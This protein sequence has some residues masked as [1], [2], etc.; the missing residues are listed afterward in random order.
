MY[1]AASALRIISSASVAASPSTIEMPMLAR[2]EL[3]LLE[4]ERPGERLE[5]ALGGV[6]RLLGGLDALEQHGELVAAEARGRVAG[7]DARGEAL[8]DLEQD[9]VAGGVAEA[10][11]DRLEVVEVDEDDRQADVVAAGA[12]DAVAHA[13]GEQ[14]A[15]REAGDRVVE[16]LMGE[17]LLERLA[18]GHV[19]AVEDDA[20]HVL[21]VEQVRVL[22]LELQRLAVAVAQG[23]LE[24]LGAAGVVVGGAV[25]QVQQPALLAGREQAGEAR[26]DDLV[27]RVAEDALDRRALVDDARVGVEH[28]DEVARGADERAEARLARAA[29]HLL[30]QRGGLERERDLGR[31]RAQTS[32]RGGRAGVLAAD[33]EQAASLR[34]DG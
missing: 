26:A 7:A 14:R 4:R 30:G 15:V 19:A 23:A 29:V 27:G 3:L 13:L 11:V 32:L 33:D 18:L 8:A 20:A 28:R 9:L 2:V 34:A 1:I 22:D 6:G 17:L 5:D 24:H 12:G 25:E 21:V 10:V 16:G 31:E